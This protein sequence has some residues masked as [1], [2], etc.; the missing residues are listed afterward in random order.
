MLA[1]RLPGTRWPL[2]LWSSKW[3]GSSRQGSSQPGR[4]WPRPGRRN[5]RWSL[6]LQACQNLCPALCLTFQS[7]LAS[8][9]FVF[10]PL[11]NCVLL[12]SLSLCH[13]LNTQSFL[14][15][16]PYIYTGSIPFIHLS[17]VL[18][19]HCAWYLNYG[20]AS[21]PC[22]LLS[23]CLTTEPCLGNCD[24][25]TVLCILM[26]FILL[27]MSHALSWYCPLNLI[28]SWYL[29]SLSYLGNVP[30]FITRTL[31]M[32]ATSLFHAS[33]SS[34]GIFYVLWHL[35]D[36]CFHEILIQPFKHAVPS[37]FSIHL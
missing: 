17:P 12:L 9:T 13:L 21:Y 22:P 29:S 32:A 3:P 8:L 24:F 4:E 18:T 28:K 19:C 33:Y 16:K 31:Y 10:C 7:G 5:R 2:Q 34:C 11:C 23:M 30:C 25:I 6:T 36:S 37:G 35:S 15:S 20:L 14:L 1:S 26:R 27:P